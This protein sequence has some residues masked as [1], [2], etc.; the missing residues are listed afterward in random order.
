MDCS[1]PGSSVHGI[2]RTRILECVEYSSG[3]PLSRDLP[4]LEIEPVSAALAGGFFT[5]EPSDKPQGNMDL[6]TKTDSYPGNWRGRLGLGAGPHA[7]EPRNSRVEREV[8]VSIQKGILP[9]LAS[10]PPSNPFQSLCA[11]HSRSPN[12]RGAPAARYR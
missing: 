5:T 9:S 12:V 10:R 2:I 6:G 3:L 11:G 4:D 8:K 7:R 1:L